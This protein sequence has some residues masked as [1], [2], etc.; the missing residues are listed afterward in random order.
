M[1]YKNAASKNLYRILVL[2]FF[3]DYASLLVFLFSGKFGDA[4]AVLKARYSF[5]RMLPG[6][7]P[8]R[9]DNIDKQKLPNIPE[10]MKGSILVSYYFKG[11]KKFSDLKFF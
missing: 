5:W 9:K 7:R 10:V 1:I 11:Q 6:Y 8:I 3:L 4:F 2:R